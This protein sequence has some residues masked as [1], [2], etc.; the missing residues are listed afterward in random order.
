MAGAWVDHGQ[1]DMDKLGGRE[2][3]KSVSL[4]NFDCF[5]CL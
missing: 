2:W 4:L 3:H 1:V 5:Y